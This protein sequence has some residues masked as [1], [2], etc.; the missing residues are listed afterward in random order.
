[1]TEHGKHMFKM[2]VKNRPYVTYIEGD[3]Y[4]FDW[5]EMQLEDYFRRF[6]KDGIVV[7]PRSLRNKLKS[8][9]SHALEAY[10]QK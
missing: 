10:E 7:S 4:H 5:P 2:I 6:G 1:M 9:Y 8:Y 3:L